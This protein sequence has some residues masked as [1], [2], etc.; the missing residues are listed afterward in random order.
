MFAVEK[1]TKNPKQS[2]TERDIQQH[3]SDCLGAQNYS[4]LRG[5]G[6]PPSTNFMKITSCVAGGHVIVHTIALMKP[7]LKN[8][9]KVIFLA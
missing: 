9:M 5:L 8:P 2:E 7:C 3:S 1:D 6:D 4:V